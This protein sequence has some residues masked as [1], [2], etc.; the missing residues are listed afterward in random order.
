MKRL[1]KRKKEEKK[2]NKLKTEV[3]RDDEDA[4][5]SADK[6]VAIKIK[7]ALGEADNAIEAITNLFGKDLVNLRDFSNKFVTTYDQHLKQ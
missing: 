4:F 1:A 7:E 2:D 6:N 3:C 5:G